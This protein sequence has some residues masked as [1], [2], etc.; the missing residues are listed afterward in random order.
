MEIDY[1]ELGIRVRHRRHEVGYTQE[2]LAEVIG[3]SPQYLAEIENSR[4]KVSL[5]VL[6]NLAERLDLSIDELI[7]G[8]ERIMAKRYLADFS[9]LLEDCSPAEGRVLYEAGKALKKVL[10][11][12]RY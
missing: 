3:I 2:H 8:E 4:K 12:N 6:A 11:S 7:Y 1:T 9:I 5:T 10:V